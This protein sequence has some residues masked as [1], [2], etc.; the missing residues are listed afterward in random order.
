MYDA[1]EVSKA[2]QKHMMQ[3]LKDGV[4]TNWEWGWNDK[5]LYTTKYLLQ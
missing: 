5:M 3:H 2:A 1:S 4:V